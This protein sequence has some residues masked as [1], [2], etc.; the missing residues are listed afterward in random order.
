[1][2][3]FRVTACSLLLMLALSVTS[4]SQDKGDDAPPPAP[5]TSDPFDS[6]GKLSWE[7][8]QA[9]L[10]NFAVAL[11]NTPGWI[12][13]IIIHAGRKSCAGE[14]RARGTRMKQYLVERRNIE[15]E[16]VIWRDDGYLEE[17]HVVLWIASPDN[18]L[19][20]RNSNSI[21]LTAKDVQIVNC[22]SKKQRRKKL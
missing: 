8:E 17:G 9:R 1:M 2:K 19:P 7:D 11:I 12:G 16:R 4:L 20:P 3:C 22:K 14:A 6:F 18:L 13:Q 10:D 15:P 5:P 21:S